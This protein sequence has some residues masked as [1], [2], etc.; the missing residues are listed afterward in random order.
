MRISAIAA[1]DE[2]RRLRLS[3]PALKNSLTVIYGPARSGKTELADLI[4]H[5]LFAKRRVAAAGSC[6]LDGELVIENANDRY[7]LRARHDETGHTRLTI[8]GVDGATV[9]HHTV[10]SLAGNLSP[11]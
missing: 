5:A 6:A 7:R 10:R 3:I 2:K 11:E 1:Y 8:A 4:G 9:D